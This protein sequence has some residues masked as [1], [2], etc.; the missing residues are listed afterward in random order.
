MTRKI[1]ELWR[2]NTANKYVRGEEFLGNWK[3]RGVSLIKDYKK[4]SELIR[5]SMYKASSCFA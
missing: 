1:S 2:L 4:I 3:P 5:C